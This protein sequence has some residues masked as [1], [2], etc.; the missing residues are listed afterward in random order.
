MRRPVW[1]PVKWSAL[2]LAA[3]LPLSAIADEKNPQAVYDQ[4]SIFADVLAIVQNEY[5]EEVDPASLV[6]NALNGALQSLDPHSSYV[7][8]VDFTEQREA[9]RREY[10]GLGIEIQS[11]GG[12]V[13]VNFAIEEG[14]AY[15]AGIRGGD[16][17]TAVDGTDIRGKSL[18]EAVS[19]MRG[20]KGEAV[21]VTVLSPDKVARDIV[22]VRDTV[23]GRAIR[24][25]VE[26][27]VGYIQIE[28]FN[29]DK[30]TEDTERALADLNTRLGKLD[31]LVI[32]LRGN[33]GG[34]L[35][36][37]VSISGL[38]LDGGEVLSAR[39]RDAS[40]NERY[41][42]E[43]GE[44]YPDAKIVV[45]V[46]PGSASAAEIVAGAL[47]DRGRGVVLGRRSFG[48]GSVQSVIP[49]G[50]EDG[51]LRLTTQRYYTPSG[52]SIQGRGIMP[53]LLVSSLEDSGEIRKRFREDSLRN[54]LSNPD[55]TD[56][57]E[58]YD[59]ILYAP[60][61]FPDDEDFQLRKA[62]EVLKTSQYERLLQAQ[63][64]KY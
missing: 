41:N 35:T 57:E 32:D 18:D 28:T 25:R 39:G 45:L 62:V 37:S 14:P 17:I 63:S 60:D 36:E 58:K 46:S 53:D 42:A 43:D 7:P 13:K 64:E 44:L 49:L 52:A 31:K 34:L 59:D 19:G 3:A 22:V 11:E 4:M 1:S 56:Y 8:P 33:R 38:F 29:N 30:L 54:F 48:K 27:G 12:L 21:T 50:A 15:K 47:Q 10:G 40:D 20:L 55:E 5:V 16:F 2:A 9:V 51:A 26:Q 23:R 61:T 6:E 24:H